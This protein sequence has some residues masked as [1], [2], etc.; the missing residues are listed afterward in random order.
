MGCYLLPK[1]EYRF[2]GVQPDSVSFSVG[3]LVPCQVPVT[4]LAPRPFLWGKL[5]V[6][7]MEAQNM[8]SSAPGNQGG[9]SRVGGAQPGALKDE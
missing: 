2:L 1:V 5:W 7:A 4:Q 8:C 9:L 6:N 3:F